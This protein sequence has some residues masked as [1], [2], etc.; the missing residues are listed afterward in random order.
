MLCGILAQPPRF[1]MT[2]CTERKSKYLLGALRWLPD[3]MAD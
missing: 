2:T 1:V 3:G